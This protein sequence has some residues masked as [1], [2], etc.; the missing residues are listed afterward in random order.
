[1]PRVL[2]GDHFVGLCAQPSYI[3]RR[4]PR[5]AND[6]KALLCRPTSDGATLSD[7]D[8]YFMFAQLAY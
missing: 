5:P 8:G 3:G 1:M 4:G 2:E 6:P 7:V